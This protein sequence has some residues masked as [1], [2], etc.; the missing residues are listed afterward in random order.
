MLEFINEEWKE[1]LQNEWEAEYFVTLHTFVKQEREQYKERIFPPEAQVFNALNHCNLSGL[2]VV[3]LGQDPYHG[4]GQANGF[5]FSV[6]DD[7]KIPPSLRNIYKEL[8]S[9]LQLEPSNSGNLV[10]WADQ[11][12]LL[13]NNVLTVREGEANSH[14]RKGW[15][16]FTD[17]ILH[18]LN[19][20]FQNIVYLLWGKD[21]HKKAQHINNE[22]N[23][24]IRT[25]H[26]SPLGCSK[27]GADF[28]A[29]MGSRCFSR[30]NK[31]LEDKGKE[32]IV[33]GK[34]QEQ[35]VLF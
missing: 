20:R 23:L 11:G 10:Q 31:Y 22:N 32:G 28:S 35:G 7:I 27:S 12:V 1:L 29:F 25:S 16:L 34:K 8:K 14:A 21:A 26:P 4:Y 30:A 5:A 9:D 15:E 3:I 24:V 6:G 33:W 19:E 2:K 17:A 18:I 13:L